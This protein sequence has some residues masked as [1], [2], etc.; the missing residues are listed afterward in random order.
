MNIFTSNA[1]RTAM[2]SESLIEAASNGAIASENA[3]GEISRRNLIAGAGAAGVLGGITGLIPGRGTDLAQATGAEDSMV[4]VK[5]FGAKGDGTTDDSAAI[6]K[7]IDETAADGRT[8]FIPGGVYMIGTTL[9]LRNN[10]MLRG[11]SR[12]VSVLRLTPKFTG[13]VFDAPQSGGVYQS[14][15]NLTLT[16]ITLDGDAAHSEATGSSVHLIRAYQSHQWYIARCMVRG[17]RGSGVG[18]LGDPR[19]STVGK[20]GPHEDTYILDC[21]FNENGLVS[22]GAGIVTKS[23]DRITLEHCTAI[24]NKGDGINIKGQFATLIGCHAVSSTNIGI[25]VDSTTNAAESTEDDAY[26]TVLGGSAEK[27]TGAGIAILR[28]SDQSVDKG[29]THATVAGFLSNEN[30]RGLGTSQPNAPYTDTAVSL[31]ILGG[32]YDWNKDQGLAINGVR[33]LVVRGTICRKN[34]TDGLQVLNTARATIAGCQLRANEG[35]GF[36][37]IAPIRAAVTR[38]PPRMR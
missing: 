21:Q 5:D 32:H 6:Q 18:L 24:K 10:L 9:L 11:A 4:S 29:V 38:K 30:G 31:A 16:D 28:N 20:Q 22:P 13:P 26:V 3:G 15:D 34:K 7:A 35:W 14:V 1:E 23:A 12:R 37:A 36:V 19:A 8:V 25:I 2:G 17:A 33:E 27:C